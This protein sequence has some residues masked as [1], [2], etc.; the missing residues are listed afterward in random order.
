M[1]G[2]GI[3]GPILPIYAESFGA[4]YIQIGLL[5]S[6]WSISRFIFSTPAGRLSDNTSK[7]RVIQGGLLIYSIV[8][9]LY[10]LATDLNLLLAIRFIHGIGSAMASPVAMAYAAEL[11]PRG[12][13]GK[14]MGTMNLAMFLGMGIGPLIGGT[15]S[16]VFTLSAPFY[17]MGAL[18]ALSL[19][20][21]TLYLPDKRVDVR[22]R[23][24]RRPLAE[25]L[26]NKTL[27]GC[28]VYRGVNS[29]GNSSIMGFL[30]I[31]MVSSIVNGGLGLS[32]TEAGWVLSIGSIGGAL[33]QRPS[34]SLADKYNK[35]HLIM[36]GGLISSIGM[37]MFV[38]SSTFY[39]CMAAQLVFGL[40]TA[41]ISPALASI[42]AI[43]GRRYGAGTTMSALESAMS[44]GMMTGPL[45]SGVLADML[46]MR[47]I[48]WVGSSISLFGIIVFYALLGKSYTPNID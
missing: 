12:Q 11:S 26:K 23:V 9:V 10:V 19:L 48:F 24:E 27:L 42:A 15:M 31:Y 44:L 30:S 39:H 28:F 43:E 33:M 22:D 34:G 47:P 5:S 35:A 38:F 21:T 2:L 45:I 41:L 25:V 1:L 13:E 18:T 6:A 16:D 46:S 17:V 37:A 36:L 4:T 7:K 8:S 29:L 20:A 32:I 14:Y 40:G 3:V